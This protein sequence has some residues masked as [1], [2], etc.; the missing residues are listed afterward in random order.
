MY[1]QNG[2]L[3][4][5]RLFGYILVIKSLIDENE[6]RLLKEQLLELDKNYPLA[7]FKNYGFPDNWKTIL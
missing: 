4:F 3:V 6:F 1:T 7:H 2:K 5:D